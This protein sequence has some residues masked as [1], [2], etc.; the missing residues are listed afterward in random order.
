M[1]VYKYTSMF[2]VTQTIEFHQANKTH[3]YLTTLSNDFKNIF[4][5][6]RGEFM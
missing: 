5:Y 1:T 2:V 3:I 6:G 4:D